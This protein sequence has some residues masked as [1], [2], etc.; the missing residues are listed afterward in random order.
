M[1]SMTV[2]MTCRLRGTWR[3]RLVGALLRFRIYIPGSFDW[4]ARGLRVQYRI[5]N[6]PWRE[7]DARFHLS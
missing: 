5:E 3:V 1:A 2:E 6:G 4:A 7:S